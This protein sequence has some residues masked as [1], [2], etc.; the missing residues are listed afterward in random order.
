LIN[1]LDIAL[2]QKESTNL[3]KFKIEQ[4]DFK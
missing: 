2:A 4:K 3:L 1:I